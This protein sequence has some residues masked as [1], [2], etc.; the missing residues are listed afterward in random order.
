MSQIEV[1]KPLLY[2]KQ[3]NRVQTNRLGWIELL[4]SNSNSLNIN[5][6]EIKLLVLDRGTWKHLTV[7]K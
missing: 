5:Y 4:V 7:C 1:L 2:L 6:V 3:F